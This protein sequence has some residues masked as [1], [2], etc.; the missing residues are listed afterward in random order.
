[1]LSLIHPST[2]ISC[3][4]I[5]QFRLYI[6]STVVIYYVL[7]PAIPKP[8]TTTLFL[9]VTSAKHTQAR[10]SLSI[11]CALGL[12]QFLRED[13]HVHQ[14]LPYLQSPRPSASCQYLFR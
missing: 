6:H 2:L 5:I 7:P 10:S 11:A 8:T 9:A 12:P 1:M 4:Y 14:H 13:Q 3:P